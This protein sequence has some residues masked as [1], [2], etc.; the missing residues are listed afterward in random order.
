MIRDLVNGAIAEGLPDL[1]SRKQRQQWAE[2]KDGS[3]RA[4]LSFLMGQKISGEDLEEMLTMEGLG[5]G[6]REG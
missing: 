5:A 4:H 3:A 6:S 2:I 1:L